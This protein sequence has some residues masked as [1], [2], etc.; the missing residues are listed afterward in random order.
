[1]KIKDLISIEKITDLR[2]KFAF[3][4]GIHQS[5]D[6]IKHLIRAICNGKDT[7]NYSIALDFP[8]NE[9]Y[10]TLSSAQLVDHFGMSKIEAL[11]FLEAIRAA[12]KK[13]N[14][15]EVIMLIRTM[16]TG[17]HIP[18]RKIDERMME[19]IREQYPNVWQEYIH[20]CKLGE[21]CDE[22]QLNEYEKIKEEE[23]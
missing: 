17:K 21:Q 7:E 5:N 12:N 11:L 20:L 4:E 6:R 2:H 13:E 22:I 16:A 1:M 3:A 15:S 14:K 9:G 8:N 23:I 19:K 10:I 18:D